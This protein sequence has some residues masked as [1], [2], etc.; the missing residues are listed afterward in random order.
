MPSFKK[1]QRFEKKYFE[2]PVL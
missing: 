2:P 1:Q